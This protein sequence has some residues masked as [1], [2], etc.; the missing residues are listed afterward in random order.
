V[1]ATREQ[2]KGGSFL[3]FNPVKY[4]MTKKNKGLRV[5]FLPLLAI[6]AAGVAAALKLN[7]GNDHARRCGTKHK[8]K[9]GDT[10][11]A[12]GKKYGVSAKELLALNKTVQEPGTKAEQRKGSQLREGELLCVRV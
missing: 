11:N 12:L 7:D 3:V 5:P 8:V 10:V 4:D 2:S 9:R 6:T 1:G